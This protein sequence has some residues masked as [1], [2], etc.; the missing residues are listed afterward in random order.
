MVNGE[1]DAFIA[2]HGRLQSVIDSAG[3]KGM[4]S[5]SDELKEQVDV[6]DGELLMHYTLFEI[7]DYAAQPLEEVSCSREAIRVIEN[8]LSSALM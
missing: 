5:T 4:C 1:I 8:K 6:S 3:F 7:D 2:R